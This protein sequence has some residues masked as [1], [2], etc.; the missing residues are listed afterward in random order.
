M[1][2]NILRLPA[3]INKTGIG[4]S[5]IYAKIASNQFPKPISLGERSVGWLE[6]DIEGW[7]NSQIEAS[8]SGAHHD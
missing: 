8:R 1:T 2:H 5:T 4:R 7:L 3:V 6:A